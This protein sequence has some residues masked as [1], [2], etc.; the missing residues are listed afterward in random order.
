MDEMSLRQQIKQ[1]DD[2]MQYILLICDE[3]N[4]ME[5]KVSDTIMF[6][7]KNGLRTETADTIQKIYIGNI[8]SKLGKMLERMRKEDNEYLAGVKA[9]L[10]NI[11]MR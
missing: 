7:R 4:Q 9:D 1:I 6:L 11:L 3:A 8:D 2:V 10:E 5:K